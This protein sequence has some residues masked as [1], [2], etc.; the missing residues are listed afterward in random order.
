MLA[1]TF[2][3]FLIFI[4]FNVRLSSLYFSSVNNHTPSF[5]HV[6]RIKANFDVA[7]PPVEA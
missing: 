4:F 6:S 7:I 2:S 3:T 1:T 5:I